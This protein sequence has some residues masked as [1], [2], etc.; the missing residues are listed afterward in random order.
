MFQ[1]RDVLRT[2]L[3]GLTASTIGRLGLTAAAAQAPPGFGFADE[4]SFDPGMVIEAARS[5][6]RQPFKALAGDLPGALSNLSYEQYVGIRLRPGAAIWAGDALGF[7]L[8]PLQRG[9]AF[10]PAMTINLVTQGTAR[11]L[12]YNQA[13]FDFGKLPPPPAL[14]DIGFSG[15]RVLAGG[16]GGFAELATFQGASFFRAVAHGQNPGTMARALSIKTGDPGGEEFPAIRT[17]WIERPSIAGGV[18]VIHALLDSQSAAGAYR[19]TIHPGD[20]TIIDTEST[21][22]ARSSVENYGL[23]TMSA[24]NLFGDMSRRRFDDVRPDVFEVG[25]LQMLTGAGEWLWR[26]VANRETLQISTFVDQN[27]HGFGFLQRDRDFT[28]YQDDDQHWERRP[29]LWIE[30]IGDWGAGG[31]QLLEIPSDS[32][33]NDNIIAYWRPKTPLA[34]GAEAAF[35]YRQFWCWSPPDR[36]PGAIVTLSRSGRGAGKRRRFLVEFT[37]E[38]LVDPLKTAS[39]VPQLNVSPGQIATTRTFPGADGKSFRVLFD[40]DPGGD[41]SAELRLVLAA[42]DRPISETW[43]YRWTA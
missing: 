20:A 12:V 21:L 15:F 1:R 25:G 9:F 43:L 42:N 6:A 38:A 2:G 4:R 22:I 33:V 36:P 34:P 31:V 10:G 37:G 41:T 40:Y 11:R 29:S 27:P 18:L 32:E 17:V 7:A 5:L 26:P 19:F 3:S 14:G 35:A 28:H 16:G 13:V 39:V 23:G 24:T 8:E 30:P